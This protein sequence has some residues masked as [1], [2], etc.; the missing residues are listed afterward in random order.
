[1]ATNGDGIST[2][3]SARSSTA[4]LDATT[5]TLAVNRSSSGSLT[6]SFRASTA[7]A[8]TAIINELDGAEHSDDGEDS[9]GENGDG[10]AS[11]DVQIRALQADLADKNRYISTLEK[12][13]LQA[14]RSSHSRVSLTFGARAS[15]SAALLDDAG[16][17]AL[18]REKDAEIADLRARLDDKDRMVAALRSAARKRDVADL[19]VDTGVA[20]RASAHS[21]AG[22]AGSAAPTASR[23]LLRD[24]PG[25]RRSASGSGPV[26]P[27]ASS[28]HAKTNSLS[29]KA[30]SL[31][32]L[33]AALS[34]GAAADA[35]KARSVD[36]MTRMLD[37]MITERAQSAGGGA[38][39]PK[40]DAR[41]DSGIVVPKPPAEKRRS[42]VR[43]L[44]S[45]VAI[46]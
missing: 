41:V 37:E 31:S 29:P 20:R 39:P 13:L 30:R 23:A 43:I 24:L 38:A 46:N 42:S 19:R 21:G 44:D 34:S 6:P 3:R 7:T 9:L 45:P 22:S 16:P 32:P 8:A 36:E 35:K 12:R 2:L 40:E 15:A 18:L 33:G 27:R 26:P 25:V 5:P 4:T 11:K 14:R 17:D 28:A 10:L 1:M